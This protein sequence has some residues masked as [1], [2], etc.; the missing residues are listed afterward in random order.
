MLNDER[1]LDV[2]RIKTIVEYIKRKHSKQEIRDLITNMHLI[3][4]QEEGLNE[5]TFAFDM[6][7]L[8]AAIF[9]ESDYCNVHPMRSRVCRIQKEDTNDDVV[10]MITKMERRKY[11]NNNALYGL[12]VFD[13]ESQTLIE[14]FLD[15]YS[16]VTS[17]RWT[18]DYL[19]TLVDMLSEV[20]PE[21]PPIL[22]PSGD[23][24]DEPKSIRYALDKALSVAREVR[25]VYFGDK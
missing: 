1:V 19:K 21:H 23:F 25:N 17:V 22:F 2:D 3:G 8:L 7:E 6:E 14:L 13:E 10:K 15:D 18:P 11:C 16:K 9:P 4:E 20:A 24:K 12:A 5:S